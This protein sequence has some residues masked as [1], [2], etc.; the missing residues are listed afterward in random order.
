M[1][2]L[3]KIRE[4]SQH[5]HKQHAQWVDDVHRWQ[6]ETKYATALLFQLERALPDHTRRLSEHLKLIDKHENIVKSYECLTEHPDFKTE[7]GQEETRLQFC[8][9][10]RDVEQEHEKLEQQYSQ[11]LESFRA[12]AKRLVDEGYVD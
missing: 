5:W 3:K 1:D 2:D 11:G 8:Q 10:H 4:Q 9:L 7:K 6:R 12:L